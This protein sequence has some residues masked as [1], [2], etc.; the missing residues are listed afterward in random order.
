[1]DNKKTE[2]I[3]ALKSCHGIVTDACRKADVPRST[4]YVWLKDD[5]DFKA[6]YDDTLE[7]AIDF[8]EGKLFEKVNGVTIRKGVD[9]ETGKDITYDL[10]PSDTAIIFYLKTKGKKRGYVERQEITPV[11]PDGN[12]IQPVININVVMPKD[13]N[14]SL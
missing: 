7:E 1:M 2:V 11:D 12:S 14:N 10:P 13:G 8:V 9:E 6:A 5:P 4:F 3:E